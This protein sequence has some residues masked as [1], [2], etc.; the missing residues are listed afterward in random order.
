MVLTKIIKI[1]SELFD[2]FI[3][4]HKISRFWN[5]PRLENLDYKKCSQ[6]YVI[7]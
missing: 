7:P 5:S 1:V 2:T 6:Q 4:K 3:L